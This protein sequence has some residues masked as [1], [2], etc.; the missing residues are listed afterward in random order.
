M[1]QILNPGLGDSPFERASLFRPDNQ[2]FL[3]NDLSAIREGVSSVF[4]IH[5]LRCVGST[6]QISARMHHIHRGRLS[7]NRLE[8]GTRVTIDPGR[9]EDFFLIQVP[10]AGRA[11]IV[12]NGQDFISSPS[13]ASLI[14]PNLPLSMCW[15][16]DAP[17]LALRIE[18]S[19]VEHHCAQHLG[20]VLDSPLE[21]HPELDLT[22]ASGGYFLQLIT[23]LADAIT[24]AQ[25]PLHHSLVLKQFESVL[26]NAL[27][28]GQPNNLQP[29][30]ECAGKPK[31]LL[32]YFVKRTEEYMRAHAGEP[33][34]IEQLAEHAG[35]SVRTLF[36]GF[37]DF[38]DTTPMAYLRNLRLEQVHLELSQLGPEASVTEIAFKWGF[39]HLGR[40][41]Q[42]YKKRYGEAPSTTRRFRR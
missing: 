1:G 35:V 8:Y 21:F 31:A 37:R 14:S 10:I 28:Y 36:A 20:H 29:Q 19:E 15:E 25:H 23:L 40:F 41:A 33:L 12:C 38:C 24:Q 16:A 3:L 32:P 7:L 17:Q 11:R 39:A 13:K 30:L 6:A 9:L 42:E 2:L 22:Q 34:S 5:E 4:K 26:I 27:V 18:R